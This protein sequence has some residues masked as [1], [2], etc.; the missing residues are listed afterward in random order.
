MKSNVTLVLSFFL[1]RGAL[2]AQTLT[3]ANSAPVPGDS[4]TVQRGS[5]VEQG[6]AGTSQ[7]WDH[8]DLVSLGATSFTY[9]TPAST[10]VSSS[11]PGSTVA[12]PVPGIPGSYVFYNSASTGFFQLGARQTGTTLFYNNAE[13]LFPYPCSYGT[14]WTDDFG[15]NYTSG[16]QSAVRTG[17]INGEADGTGTLILPFG[18]VENVIRIHVVEFSEDVLSG[19]PYF[20]YASDHYVFYKPGFRG[21]ILGIYQTTSATFGTPTEVNYTQWVDGADVSVQDLLDNSIGIDVF[22]VPATNE[23]NVLFSSQGGAVDFTVMDAQGRIVHQ[24]N[25]GASS[26]VD[27]QVLDVRTLSSGVYHL[28]I[29]ARNGDQGLRRFVVE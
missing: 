2:P 19:V 8:S 14:T 6:N 11:F 5:Y 18:T 16:G 20:T 24:E 17:T 27:R 13:T 22:P 7:T 12:L 15:S 4:Y 29:T 25:R 10:G 21:P 3:Q 9:V 28:R 26:G 1:L 23:L